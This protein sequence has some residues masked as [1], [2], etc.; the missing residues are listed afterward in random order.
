MISNL[1]QKFP[2]KIVPEKLEIKIMHDRS[3]AE[4]DEFLFVFAN[5]EITCLYYIV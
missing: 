5:Q 4:I 2:V 1:C 3:V